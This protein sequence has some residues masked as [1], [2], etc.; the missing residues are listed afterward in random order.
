[1]FLDFQKAFD[2]VSHAFILN[3]L[4]KFNSGESFKEWINQMYRN[5]EQT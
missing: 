5:A 1:M 2:T 3:V 4:T